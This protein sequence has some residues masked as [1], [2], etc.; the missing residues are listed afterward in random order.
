MARPSPE[1]RAQRE[2]RKQRWA[3]AREQAAAERAAIDMQVRTIADGAIVKAEALKPELPGL[4]DLLDELEEA[5][6][7][8]L[9]TEAPAAAVQATMAKGKLLGLWVDKQAIVT[10][11]PDQF[12]NADEEQAHIHGDIAQRFGP[13]GLQKFRAFVNEMRALEAEDAKLLEHETE[14]KVDAARRR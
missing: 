11:T 13:K 3:E 4:I 5:R 8:A 7:V 1:V 14:V 9:A 10:G 2:E 6:Q 12:R